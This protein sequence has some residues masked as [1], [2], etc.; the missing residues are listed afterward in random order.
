M[1]GNN[2]NLDVHGTNS[3][4]LADV[5]MDNYKRLY[6]IHRMGLKDKDVGDL[7]ERIALRKRLN[8]KSFKWY[9]DN[10]IPE[11]FIPDENV[12]SYGLVRNPESQLCLDTLQR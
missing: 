3:K 4:R 6:Y 1:T 7:S 12:A 10:V 8:C 9:L 5:W 11:K 2:G